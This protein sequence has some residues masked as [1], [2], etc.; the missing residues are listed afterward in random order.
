M[1][2]LHLTKQMKRLVMFLCAALWI[3][4]LPMIAASPMHL[5]WEQLAIVI[6]KPVS[7][8]QPG[9]SVVIGK[10][11]AVESDALLVT[12]KKKGIVRVPRA[13][14]RRFEMQ[15]KGK[16]YRIIATPIA[17][18]AGAVAGVGAAI[19]IQGGL[20]SSDNQGA[21]AVALVGIWAGATVAGYFAGNAADK[22][23][24]PVEIID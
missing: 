11:T 16:K 20:F 19:G 21:A 2:R 9:G 6:G 1:K 12:V 24:T 13:N 8:A 14:L 17:S 3:L 18:V 23:W 4:P 7:I 22:H 15:T 5:K 10:A